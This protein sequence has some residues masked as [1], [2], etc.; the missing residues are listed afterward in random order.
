MIAQ[1][2]IQNYLGYFLFSGRPHGPIS[3]ESNLLPR[4][5]LEIAGR[6]RSSYSEDLKEFVNPKRRF[7]TLA[8][9]V[10]V[11]DRHPSIFSQCL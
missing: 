3:R 8:S 2:Y 10:F 7:S 9:F 11:R 6:D 1:L 5:D 4:R